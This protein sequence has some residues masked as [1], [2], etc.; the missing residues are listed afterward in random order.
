[1][2]QQNHK[3]DYHTSQ[4]TLDVVLVCYCFF[5]LLSLFRKKSTHLFLIIVIELIDVHLGRSS[6]TVIVSGL[7]RHYSQR[8]VP[9]QPTSLFRAEPSHNSPTLCAL[10][11]SNPA[12]SLDGGRPPM[13]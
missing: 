1:M 7:A 2:G 12:Q 6:A 9:V 5:P 10:G 11:G 8:I 13:Q 3:E 4:V